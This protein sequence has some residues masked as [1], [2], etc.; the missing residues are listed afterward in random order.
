[1]RFAL[2]VVLSLPL[3]AAGKGSILAIFSHPDDETAAGP[4]LAKYAAA[5][6]E[7]NVVAITSGQ[8]GTTPNTRL[9]G[10]ELGAAR[11]EELRCSARALGIR[12]PVLLRYQDQGISAPPVMEQVAGRL[13][14]I[15]AQTKPDIVITWGPEGVTGHPD[16]RVTHSIVW[17]VFQ[18]RGL[19]SHKPRKLYHLTFPEALFSAAPGGRRRPFHTVSG[20]FITAEIDVR[21][22]LDAAGRSIRCHKTQWDDAR[23]QEMDAMN[24]ATL[25]GR[26]YLRLAMGDVPPPAGRREKD[27]FEGLNP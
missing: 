5:G 19:L 24:R 14:E 15:I 22:F 11:E 2:L 13:R 8:K 16:H 20:E 4:L 9:A 12:P 17:Q 1:M 10:D 25:A 6:H 21:G 18:Q 7:V 26:S 3:T 23:M 27:L